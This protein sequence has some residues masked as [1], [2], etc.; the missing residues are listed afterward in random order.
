MGVRRDG[1]CSFPG[2]PAKNILKNSFL[3]KK[4]VFVPWKTVCGRPW[5]LAIIKP[6]ICK[7]QKEQENFNQWSL[8]SGHRRRPQVWLRCCRLLAGHDRRGPDTSGSL[9]LARHQATRSATG[10]KTVKVID[11][12]KSKCN[13]VIVNFDFMKPTLTSVVVARKY[14][15]PLY[16]FRT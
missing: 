6:L 16:S 10:K 8:N 11:K 14:D 12:A 4:Y 3:G 13:L 5:L 9:R 1:S 15:H 7:N 2:R